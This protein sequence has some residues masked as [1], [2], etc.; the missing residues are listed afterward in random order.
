[1]PTARTSWT[2]DSFLKDMKKAVVAG[3]NAG[4][5]VLQKEMKQ[6]MGTGAEDSRG[7]VAAVQLSRKVRNPDGKFRRIRTRK[8]VY[9]AARAGEFPGVR[10]G[11]L[12]QSINVAKATEN[13]MSAAIGT[14]K[15]YGR[16]LEY[17]TYGANGQK[18]RPRPWALRS[19]NMAKQAMVAQTNKTVS[20]YLDARAGGTK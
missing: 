11:T 5:I 6:N 14:N 9:R 15:K 2:G 1:M 16:W 18:M 12:R 7:A 17:G 19:L 13:D 10:T 20:D 3:V 8:N 4:A